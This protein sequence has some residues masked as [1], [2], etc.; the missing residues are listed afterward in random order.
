MFVISPAERRRSHCLRPW[1]G[2]W[3]RIKE[4]RGQPVRLSREE[5]GEIKSTILT[6]RALPG[7]GDSPVLKAAASN[8]AFNAALR[9]PH[10][11]PRVA[12]M[13]ETCCVLTPLVRN[14]ASARL[15]ASA[16]DAGASAALAKV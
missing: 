8:A 5:R 16:R 12:E 14:E 7:P 9:R 3:R 11:A 13:S 4:H 1:Q 2:P 10:S 15:G 6:A